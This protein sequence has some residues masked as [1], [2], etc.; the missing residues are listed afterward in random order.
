MWEA[1]ETE[2]G[3]LH[4]DSQWDPLLYVW[5]H[6]A[7]GVQL[8][9][10]FKPVAF[11]NNQWLHWLKYRLP[12]MTENKNLEMMTGF[13]PPFSH[14]QESPAQPPVHPQSSTSQGSTFC[15][16]PEDTLPT[17]TIEPCFLRPA[18]HSSSFHI[19]LFGT[20][21]TQSFAYSMDVL[22]IC[23]ASWGWINKSLKTLNCNSVHIAYGVYNTHT[24][25][26]NQ[27][28][29]PRYLGQ[30]SHIYFRNKGELSLESFCAKTKD[31]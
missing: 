2:F 28:L 25:P 12:N 11:Q 23:T 30:S 27:S 4:H 1:N 24:L 31:V 9:L 3:R 7:P 22:S 29:W 14:S 19:C 10:F 16:L 13:P 15:C 5:T 8:T 17:G 18:S 20:F 6:H 26:V 21:K